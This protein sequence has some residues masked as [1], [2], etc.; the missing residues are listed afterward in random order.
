MKKISLIVVCTAY[1][2]LIAAI[3]VQ[4]RALESRP[5]RSTPSGY[6]SGIEEDEEV[7]DFL[8]R[9][10]H[11]LAQNYNF[12]NLRKRNLDLGFS[13]GFSGSQAAKH[14]MG[15]A[16]ANYAGGPG[17]KRRSLSAQNLANTQSILDQ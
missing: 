3:L 4:C 16:V 13:R 12:D 7:A 2:F 15:L 14:L 5:V 8:E 1:I 10:G 17:R 9:L 11:H 6:E